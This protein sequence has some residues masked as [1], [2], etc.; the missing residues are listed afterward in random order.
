MSLLQLAEPRPPRSLLLESRK[1]FAP[2]VER[3][4]TVQAS[5]VTELF[6]EI[7][8]LTRVSSFLAGTTRPL[9]HQRDVAILQLLLALGPLRASDLATLLQLSRATVTRLIDGLERSGLLQREPDPHDRRAIRLHLTPSGRLIGFADVA[10]A[11]A[12]TSAL[13]SLE[14][15]ELTA[16][17]TGLQALSRNLKQHLPANHTLRPA[18]SRRRST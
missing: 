1:H 2:E 17:Q 10:P 7:V 12:L 9:P 13:D 18:Y 8:V 15:E 16:L 6:F 4:T 14:P 11:S 5:L 3:M